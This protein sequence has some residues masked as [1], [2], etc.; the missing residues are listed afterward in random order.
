MFNTYVA[1][2]PKLLG[3]RI[4]YHEK[5][6]D[7]FVRT[8][9]EQVKRNMEKLWK[10]RIHILFE[11]SLKR[12]NHTKICASSVISSWSSTKAWSS[13]IR[14]FPIKLIKSGVGEDTLRLFEIT[15]CRLLAPSIRYDEIIN[16]DIT[17]VADTS[18]T[19]HFDVEDLSD[20]S[21]VDLSGSPYVSLSSATCENPFEKE[22]NLLI[23]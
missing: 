8:K 9:N 5:G 3:I 11:E 20:T 23:R 22:E 13:S 7:Y 19:F 4:L 1:H 18:D 2:T 15:M 10:L 16:G 6:L 17:S 21:D 14:A 12:S